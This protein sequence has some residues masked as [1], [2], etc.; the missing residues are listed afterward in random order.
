LR[1]FKGHRKCIYSTVWHPKNPDLFASTSGDCTLK[2]WDCNGSVGCILFVTERDWLCSG[3]A[4]RLSAV[5]I[6]SSFHGVSCFD[7]PLDEKAV[8]TIPAHK[9]EIMTCEV[10]WAS[11]IVLLAGHSESHERSYESTARA[12]VCCK[13]DK[14]FPLQRT[15][16]SIG[17]LV[18]VVL[19]TLTT[20]LS[21]CYFRETVAHAPT[22]A[23]F[24]VICP[25][26]C[27]TPQKRT[28]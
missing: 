3:G 22:L 9:Y 4:D 11:S 28:A 15:H 10:I 1:T 14:V 23:V 16:H 2:I 17:I 21:F 12:R 8:Q 18:S 7:L 25:H 13:E 27:G 26:A 24:V 19:F 6:A 20:S 5:L